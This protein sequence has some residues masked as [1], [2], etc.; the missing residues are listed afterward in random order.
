MNECKNV[1][2]NVIKYL[3]YVSLFCTFVI[4]DFELFEKVIN[5]I[6]KIN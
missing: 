4:N 6:V 2:K 1:C 5:E 3:K